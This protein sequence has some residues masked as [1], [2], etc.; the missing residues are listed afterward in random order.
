MVNPRYP[1]GLFIQVGS[2]ES[3]ILAKKYLDRVASHKRL[4]FPLYMENLVLEAIA[5]QNDH[6]G[7]II[8]NEEKLNWIKDYLHLFDKVFVGSLWV[9]KDGV[10]TDESRWANIHGTVDVAKQFIKYRQD[11][12]ITIPIHWYIEL[13]AD[14]NWFNSTEPSNNPRDLYT[15]YI[16]EL[17]EE[18]A[19]ISK[20]KGLNYPPNLDFLWSP[21]WTKNLKDV[22]GDRPVLIKNIKSLLGNA[23]L[24]TWLHLQ[25]GIGG[26]SIKHSDGSITYNRNAQD[27]IDFFNLLVEANSEFQTLRSGIINMEFFVTKEDNTLDPGDPLEQ[28]ERTLQYRQ[29]GIPVGIS[30]EISWWSRSLYGDT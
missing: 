13:E 28:E 27:A 1:T 16:M 4:G 18:L 9:G 10:W 11:N 19:K 5:Y 8:F 14:L 22:P 20:D 3:E 7:P 30:W 15:W 23:P 21:F 2:L 6:A 29:A 24:L 26:Q 17:T 12:N 25:D